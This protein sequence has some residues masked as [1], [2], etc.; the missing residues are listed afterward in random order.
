MM[1]HQVLIYIIIDDSSKDA[2]V[3]IFHDSSVS[4]EEGLGA[5]SEGRTYNTQL[6]LHWKWLSPTV[7]TVLLFQ[8]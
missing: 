7:L 6:E 3:S 5:W 2:D 4:V 8:L 1:S